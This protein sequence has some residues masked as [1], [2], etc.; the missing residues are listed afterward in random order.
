M[1]D[2]ECLL[3]VALGAPVVLV[4]FLN[5]QHLHHP[6]VECLLRVALGAPIV[7][8]EFLNPRRLLIHV[9]QHLTKVPTKVPHLRVRGV[10][11]LT[12]RQ[13]P[14]SEQP[15]RRECYY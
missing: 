4:E 13:R 7:L 15:P 2:V 5:P 6:V 14:G 10:I 11:P 9:Y 3:R 1:F 12:S 8:V